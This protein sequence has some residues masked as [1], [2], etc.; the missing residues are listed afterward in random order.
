MDNAASPESIRDDF[1]GD[2]ENATPPDD[3][4]DDGDDDDDEEEE[5]EFGDEEKVETPRDIFL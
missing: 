4:D 1:G 5:E 2:V 3:D